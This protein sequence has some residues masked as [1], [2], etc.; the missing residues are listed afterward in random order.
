MLNT[1][2][3]EI[4]MAEKFL[5]TKSGTRLINY[6]GVKYTDFLSE[7]KIMLSL[8]FHSGFTFRSFSTTVDTEKEFENQI[9]FRIMKSLTSAGVLKSVARRI[10]KQITKKK[11]GRA[12]V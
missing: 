9:Q 7:N 11:I 3:G 4:K 10:R 5:V 6:Y 1:L 2:M 8:G 12:H